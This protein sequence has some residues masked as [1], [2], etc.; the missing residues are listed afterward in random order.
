MKLSVISSLIISLLSFPAVARPLLKTPRTSYGRVKEM[1]VDPTRFVLLKAVI[2]QGPTDKI[3]SKLKALDEMPAPIYMIINTPG[4]NVESGFE[5][6][7]TVQSLKSPLICII[8]SK[9]YSMGALLASYCPKLYIHKFGMVMFHEA[10]YTV[11]GNTT[12][13]HVRVNAIEKHL[14]ELFSDVAKQLDISP[15]AFRNKIHDEW[16]ISATESAAIGFTDGVIEKL[17][18]PNV[19]A[20]ADDNLFEMMKKFLKGD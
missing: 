13:V 7:Q 10:A 1:V 19:N 12:Q 9:A 5:L 17:T 6:V 16:W 14:D 4:G 3:N 20:G 15:Q 2:E 11:Q 8:E 18:Y